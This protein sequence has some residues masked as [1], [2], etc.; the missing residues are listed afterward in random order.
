[1][2]LFEDK[3]YNF[4]EVENKLRNNIVDNRDKRFIL[5]AL[6]AIFYVDDGITVAAET[7]ELLLVND[8][9]AS[10]VGVDAWELIGK[11]TNSLAAQGII[12]TSVAEMAMNEKK[13]KTI[14]Q[15]QENGKT[16]LNTAKPI[17]NEGGKVCRAVSTIRDMPILQELYND[18]LKQKKLLEGYKQT[19]NI[20]NKRNIGEIITESEKMRAIVNL[21]ERVATTDSTVL[22][23]GESGVGKGIIADLIH[24]LSARSECHKVSINCG[25]IPEQLLESELFGYCRGAFTGANKEGKVGLIEAAEGGTVILDEIGELP[26]PLQPKLLK[27]LETGEISKVGST[28]TKKVDSRI[29]AVTNKDL[30]EMVDAG[31]FR[32]DLYYRLNVIPIEIPPLRERRE[33]IIP[34]ILLF[35]SRYN[36]KNGYDKTITPEMLKKM[37]RFNWPGNIRQLRNMIERLVVLSPGSEIQATDLGD[38]MIQNEEKHS[39]EEIEWPVQLGEITQGLEERYIKIALNKAGSIREAA[40]LL[41]I[42]PSMLFRK[43]NR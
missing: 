25:A 37:Q 28:D 30:K 14:V 36:R 10:I 27:Y 2:I 42:S 8:V 18:L 20:Q 22:I 26:M 19:L 43:M 24:S 6:R 41:G 3:A 12:E 34:L 32:E 13:Q 38:S 15:N 23:L 33:D 40:K 17:F 16:V 1:M 9:Y 4:E 31:T 11:K 29:I 35:L 21:S 7:L 5:E 39:S